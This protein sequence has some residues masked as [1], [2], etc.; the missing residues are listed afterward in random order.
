MNIKKQAKL[1]S[2]LV[3][4]YRDFIKEFYPG[5]NTAD[6]ERAASILWN[7]RHDR[8]KS[9]WLVAI[10]NAYWLNRDLPTVLS[11]KDFLS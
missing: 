4:A 6:A 8:H 11:R 3:N 5:F 1:K 7:G 2:E 10:D 9:D